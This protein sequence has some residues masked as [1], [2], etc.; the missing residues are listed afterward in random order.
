ML[1]K[2]ERG[3]H[4]TCAS[5]RGAGTVSPRCTS[6]GC[7]GASSCSRHS[8]T[9]IGGEPNNYLDELGQWNRG[10]KKDDDLCRWSGTEPD[11]DYHHDQSVATKHRSMKTELFP[12]EGGKPWA[13]R[14]RVEQMRNL[15]L[16]LL[17]GATCSVFACCEL[18]GICTSALTHIS[19]PSWQQFVE[20]RIL[21][22]ALASR[23]PMLTT[24]TN[25]R[26]MPELSETR[27]L[28]S[29]VN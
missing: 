15:N 9:G 21:Q 8:R 24:A 10:T 2:Y 17:A 1:F 11:Y 4:D 13:F 5:N 12:L 19:I 14:K 20:Q 23:F 3:R 28:L 29:G 18:L 22:D 7:R 25:T 6:T 27:L 16:L 26:P